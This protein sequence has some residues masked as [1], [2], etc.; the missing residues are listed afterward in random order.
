M[1]ELLRG[2]L[3]ALKVDD[4]ETAPRSLLAPPD[5]ASSSM[6]DAAAMRG[7]RVG[8]ASRWSLSVS[9]TNGPSGQS[10]TWTSRRLRVTT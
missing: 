1:L 10:K 5:D 4:P 9:S 8:T 6:E 2:L 7:L 3:S